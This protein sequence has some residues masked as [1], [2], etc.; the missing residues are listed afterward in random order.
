MILKHEQSQ[1]FRFDSEVFS[2]A[3]PE[4]LIFVGDQSAISQPSVSTNEVDSAEGDV[5]GE[6]TNESSNVD[7]D[8]QKLWGDYRNICRSAME[9]EIGWGG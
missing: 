1:F 6:Q 8:G 7:R 4:P 3:R 2:E 9:A 5:S